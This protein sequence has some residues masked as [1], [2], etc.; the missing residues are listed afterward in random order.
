MYLVAWWAIGPGE[1]LRMVCATPVD[2]LNP[3]NSR[4]NNKPAALWLVCSVNLAIIGSK[5]LIEKIR[6]S[7]KVQRA[8]DLPPIIITLLYDYD[9]YCTV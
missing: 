8:L 5:G 6:V 2:V 4:A 3:L 9:Y 1:W 7:L